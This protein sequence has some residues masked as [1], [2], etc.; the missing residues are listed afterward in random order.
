MSEK[1][2]KDYKITIKYNEDK[3]ETCEKLLDLMLRFIVESNLLYKTNNES[4][5]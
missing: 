3:Q 2:K 1:Q 5:S 4:D